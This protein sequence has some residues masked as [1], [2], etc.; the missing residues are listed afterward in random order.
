M[1]GQRTVWRSSPTGNGMT[2]LV[3]SSALLSV[4]SEPLEVKDRTILGQK[5]SQ[6]VCY[7][8]DLYVVNILIKG[9]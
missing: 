5:L 3:E 9:V 4:S 7:G 6:S 8:S 2:R 1:V